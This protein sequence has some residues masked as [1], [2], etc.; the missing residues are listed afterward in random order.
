MVSM[1][2][3]TKL[4]ERLKKDRFKAVAFSLLVLVAIS[5]AAFGLFGKGIK[6]ADQPADVKVTEDVPQ[7][8]ETFDDFG[9][10]IESLKISVPIIPEVDGLN[11]K[12]YYAALKKG[13]AQ[14]KGSQTPDK[15]GNLF[16]FG[17]SSF[18]KG[19]EGNYKE[20]FKELNRLKV[21]DQIMVYHNKTPYLYKVTKSFETTDTDWTLLDP[22]PKVDS[23]KTLTLMTCWPPG[24]T[25]K[26][27]GVVAIQI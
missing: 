7:P 22:T 3:L 20:V 25:T 6:K 2:S 19:V 9:L 8:L 14:Y 12:I 10:K 13:V 11:E 4:I 16:I 17:H 1:E 24:T 15:T 27:W 5:A 23:D 21:D 18:F 26:R